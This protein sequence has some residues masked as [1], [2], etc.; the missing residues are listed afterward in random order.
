MKMIGNVYN[1][2]YFGTS[3]LEECTWNAKCAKDTCRMKG[4]Y[5]GQ[6]TLL[7]SDT[8]NWIQIYG[9]TEHAY[10]FHFILHVKIIF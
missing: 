2:M 10:I 6:W 1:A 8:E 4:T 9:N 5:K 7:A 3:T